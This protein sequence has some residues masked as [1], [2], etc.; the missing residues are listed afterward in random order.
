[1]A[2]LSTW[3]WYGRA[4]DAGDGESVAAA[5]EHPEPGGD[6]A[7]DDAGEGET[8]TLL[9]ALPDLAAGDVPHDRADRTEAQ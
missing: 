8:V 7:D 6:P 4:E 5:A 2:G 1:M 9:A 3:C